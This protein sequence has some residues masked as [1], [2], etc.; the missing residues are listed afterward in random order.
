[1]LGET[2]ATGLASRGIPVVS[3]MDASA[4]D[5]LTITGTYYLE[6]DFIRFEGRV[7]S[8]SRGIVLKQLPAIRIPRIALTADL[9]QGQVVNAIVETQNVGQR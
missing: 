2:I 7:L 1:M 3:A 4:T 5:G 6:G 8:A 9:A